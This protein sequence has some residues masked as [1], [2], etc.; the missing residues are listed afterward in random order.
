VTPQRVLIYRELARSKDHPSP[1]VLYER[2]RR[3]APEISFDTVYRSLSTFREI[4]VV[5]LVEG[6]GT[7]MRFDPTTTNHHHFRCVRCETIIDF[8]NETYDELPVPGAIG[9]RFDVHKIRVT[10]EGLCAKCRAKTR[11]RR[12]RASRPQGIGRQQ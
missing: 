5:D 1:E 10:V 4:G 3:R 8:K 9:R 6:Y 2:V 11:S 12:R 7:A